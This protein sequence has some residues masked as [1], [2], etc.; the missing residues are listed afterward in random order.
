MF[1]GKMY[2]EAY[3]HEQI[4][5]KRLQILQEMPEL[6]DTSEMKVFMLANGQISDIRSIEP[7]EFEMQPNEPLW[8]DSEDSD[9]DDDDDF[10]SL[11]RLNHSSMDK[12]PQQRPVMR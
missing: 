4:K 5:R 10:D 7:E 6:A 3:M 8:S 9:S 11:N 12:L 2:D 1:D